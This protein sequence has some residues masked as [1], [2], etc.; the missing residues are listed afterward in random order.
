MG[1]EAWRKRPQGNPGSERNLSVRWGSCG[2]G[3]VGEGRGGHP[4]SGNGP[5]ESKSMACLGNGDYPG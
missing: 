1:L 3:G 5:S 2:H 4:G